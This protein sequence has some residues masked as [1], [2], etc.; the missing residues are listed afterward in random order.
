M[1]YVL[2]PSS[3]LH[4]ILTNEFACVYVFIIWYKRL[5][6]RYFSAKLLV[7]C[8]QMKVSPPQCPK[9]KIHR[10]A[11]TSVVMFLNL[12][13]ILKC[14]RKIKTGA[15][16][17]SKTATSLHLSNCTGQQYCW[18][19]GS[20]KPGRQLTMKYLLTGSEVLLRAGT[21][22]CDR[23]GCTYRRICTMTAPSDS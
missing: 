8:P 23:I 3:D 12:K 21:Q 2:W 22:V 17:I 9:M 10:T 14:S 5:H 16:S 4:Y 18:F 15:E 11:T 20:A 1:L 7:V 13:L 19:N 6:T